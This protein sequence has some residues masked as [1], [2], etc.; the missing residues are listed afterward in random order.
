MVSM[1]PLV[2]MDKRLAS[3][4]QAIQR[5]RTAPARRVGGN[6]KLF[7]RHTAA[8]RPYGLS[9][10]VP[11]V[12]VS[13]QQ[14][15]ATV[16]VTPLSAHCPAS[17]GRDTQTPAPLQ[18]LPAQQT[19]PVEVHSWPRP[20]HTRPPSGSVHWNMSAPA[21]PT[22]CPASTQ[23]PTRQPTRSQ[24]CRGVR[25][26]ASAIT[27][28]PRIHSPERIGDSPPDVVLRGVRGTLVPT[29]KPQDDLPAGRMSKLPSRV[30]T[31]PGRPA[32]ST[33]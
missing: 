33:F 1:A 7:R 19:A 4:Q 15:E 23:M 9:T 32:R 5:C 26:Q 28:N 30:G 17:G 13:E 16:Q 3:S 21:S 27:A 22:L 2:L 18:V 24:R 10:Q 8:P 29:S 11:F 14:L 31:C 12:Q 20:A 25:P 6:R